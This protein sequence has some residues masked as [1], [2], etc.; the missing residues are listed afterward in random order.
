MGLGLLGRGLG[1]ARFLAEIGAQVLVTDLKTKEQLASSLDELKG[2]S[3]I[4]YVLGEHRLEDFQSCDM[5]IK[6][7][8]VPLNSVYITEARKHNIPVEMDASLFAKYTEATLIG[9]TGTRGKS[10]TTQA[11][12]E[13]LKTYYKKGQVF[14]GGNVRGLATLPLLSEAKKGD[15]VVL[16]LDS[17]QMQGFGEARISPHIAVFTNFMEDH[18]NYYMKVSK[19]HAEAMSLYFKDKAQIFGNQKVGDVFVTG[20]QVAE[21]LNGQYSSVPKG[22]GKMIVVDKNM[23]PANMTLQIPGEHNREN[24]AQAYAAL[25]AFAEEAGLSEADIIAG[26]QAFKGVP[27]RLELVREVKG[28]KIYNDTNSTTPAAAVAALKAF[29]EPTR[30][31]VLIMGGFDKA[32]DM[33]ELAAEIP[34]YCKSVVLLAGTGTEKFM[35]NYATKIGPTTVVAS[36][37]EGVKLAI[38]QCQQGDILVLSPAFASFGMFKNE[39]DRGD[40]F[41]E[42][43]KGV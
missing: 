7:A 11:I 35:A 26:L 27:G 2:F 17:W 6:S 15:V 1:D 34:K 18:L 4:T 36:L 33:S 29:G 9:I 30:R 42:V 14:L 41:N 28:V 23:L 39:Y 31:I 24:M 19:D 21:F 38:S 3:N 8:D 20:K 37:K 43:V 12:Y 22:A 25:Q 10:T 13:I 5:V 32:L 40:Q 16:E